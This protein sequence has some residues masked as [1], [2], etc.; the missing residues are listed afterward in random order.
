G[1]TLL[2]NILNELPGVVHVGELTYV[3]ET[4]WLADRSCGCGNSFQDCPFWSRVAAVGFDG[5]DVAHAHD[6]IRLRN[7]V[8]SA[9]R[10]AGSVLRWES[11]S[12]NKKEYSAILSQVYTAI[13]IASGRNVIVVSSKL[14]IQLY[15]LLT[16]QSIELCILHLVRDPR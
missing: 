15:P 3:W 5:F 9:R 1:S 4:G 13:G 14:P 6:A 2:G 8:A 7:H 12:P 10:I 16:L 11:E